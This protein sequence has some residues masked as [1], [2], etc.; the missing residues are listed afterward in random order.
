MG[1]WGVRVC[2]RVCELCVR[3]VCAWAFKCA[4]YGACGAQTRRPTPS[5]LLILTSHSS[6]NLHVEPARRTQLNTQKKKEPKKSSR[7]NKFK[8]HITI[9]PPSPRSNLRQLRPRRAA[10]LNPVGINPNKRHY[11]TLCM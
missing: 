3:C 10:A 9:S 1:D 6:A 4:H 8:P 2:A 5:P 7:Y 11:V